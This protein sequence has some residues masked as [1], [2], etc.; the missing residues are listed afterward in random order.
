MQFVRNAVTV[1]FIPLK[2]V[3]LTKML[4][5]KLSTIIGWNGNPIAEQISIFF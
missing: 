4:W 5:L 3:E 2:E 1:K